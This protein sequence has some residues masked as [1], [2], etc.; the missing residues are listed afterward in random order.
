M[1]EFTVNL[2]GK[3]RLHHS[4]VYGLVNMGRGSKQGYVDC[5]FCDAKISCY[6]WSISGSGKKCSCGAILRSKTAVRDI[7]FND[8][9]FVFKQLEGPLPANGRYYKDMTEPKV[10]MLVALHNVFPPENKHNLGMIVQIKN[11]PLGFNYGVEE[12]SNRKV[13]FHHI[14]TIIPVELVSAD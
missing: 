4:G 3:I 2:D 8:K 9:R 11:D 1:T 14:S 10:G 7:D 5:P 12:Y 6:L 13:Y